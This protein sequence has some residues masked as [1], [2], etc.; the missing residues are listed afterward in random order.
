MIRPS[1]YSL[2]HPSIYSFIHSVVSSSIHLLIYPSIHPFVNEWITLC[3]HF[4]PIRAVI[5]SPMLIQRCCV[6]LGHQEDVCW[7]HAREA[8]PV[9]EENQDGESS[10]SDRRG[11][12]L[13]PS[14][15]VNF[16]PHQ[17]P[18]TKKYSY[19]NS[20]NTI[21]RIKVFH[22]NGVTIR[23]PSSGERTRFDQNDFWSSHH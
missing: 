21:L 22:L 1:I 11:P 9:P 17:P 23:S 5:V 20:K 6:S 18:S 14:L 15:C 2:N 16:R 12:F 13:S 3:T 4:P 7:R 19:W 10:G 8:H